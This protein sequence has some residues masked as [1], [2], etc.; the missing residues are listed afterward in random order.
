MSNIISVE[1]KTVEV[2]KEER[3]NKLEIF[4]PK[5]E[6]YWGQLHHE[7]VELHDGDLKNSV[8]TGDSPITFTI[9]EIF[10][11]MDNL[12]YTDLQGAE[13]TIKCQDVPIIV[14]AFCD[15]IRSEAE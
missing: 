7:T 6:E 4:T 2:T 5:G 9:S 12:T 10:T 11:R 13:Q 3:T 8:S 14:Q 1:N 15:V